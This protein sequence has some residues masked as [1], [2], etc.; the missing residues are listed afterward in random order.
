MR[1][2]IGKKLGIAFT[3]VIVMI[4]IAEVIGIV[5]MGSSIVSL[6]KIPEERLAMA[7]ATMEVKA[8]GSDQRCALTNVL[9]FGN[10]R[11]TFDKQ[12]AIFETKS[13]QMNEWM[14]EVEKYLTSQ[15]ISDSIR[16]LYNTF[17]QQV[18]K[19]EKLMR[20][21]IDIYQSEGMPTAAALVRGKR[22][23]VRLFPG[24]GMREALS[25]LLPNQPPH[26]SHYPE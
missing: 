17:K 2:T 7:L 1:R 18:S 20:T 24:V 19:D 22:S 12:L 10:N 23:R 5:M 4:L 16:D 25:R 3:I 9:L 26:D 6:R 11:E 8:N 15:S 21:A 13:K 14:R